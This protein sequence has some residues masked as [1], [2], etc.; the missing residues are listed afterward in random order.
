METTETST[1]NINTKKTL[2][3]SIVVLVLGISSI[4]LCWIDFWTPMLFFLYPP[5]G[6][7]FGFLGKSFAKKGFEMYNLSP[8]SYT[9]CQ[10]LK[11]GRTLSIIGIVVGFISLVVGIIVGICI[12]AGAAG[13]ATDI[14]W[15]LLS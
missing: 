1:E 11:V 10:M 7:V 14:F 9:G 2:I 5:L 6:I 8:S 15:P 13:E 4:E 12:I 3:Y